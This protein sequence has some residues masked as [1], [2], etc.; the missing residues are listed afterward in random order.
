VLLSFLCHKETS[1]FQEYSKKFSSKFKF[2]LALYW[3]SVLTLLWLFMVCVITHF[4]YNGATV[5]M[6]IYRQLSAPIRKSSPI[7]SC[8]YAGIIRALPLPQHHC[9]ISIVKRPKKS[10]KA[11]R[12]FKANQLHEAKKGQTNFFRPTN[13]KRGRISE[14]WPKKGQPGNPAGIRTKTWFSIMTVSI[15]VFSKK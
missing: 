7:H 2:C 13:L 12:I 5:C 14:I 1:K 8:T 10:Q 4:A 6:L 9:L 3:S 11:K 15:C